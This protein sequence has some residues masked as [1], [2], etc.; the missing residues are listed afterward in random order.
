MCEKGLLPYLQKNKQK[1]NDSTSNSDIF[2]FISLLCKLFGRT[3]YAYNRRISFQTHCQNNNVKNKFS[4]LPQYP[5]T[6]EF[7]A[8]CVARGRGRN[9]MRP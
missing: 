6:R 3:D 8:R 1:Y 2:N 5:Q 7:Q 9:P 4:S